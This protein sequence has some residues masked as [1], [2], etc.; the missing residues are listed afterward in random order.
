MQIL[1][2]TNSNFN[3]CVPTTHCPL[4]FFF[5]GDF[6]VADEPTLTRAVSIPAPVYYAHWAAQRG[7]EYIKA[8]I[9]GDSS[10]GSIAS[11]SSSYKVDDFRHAQEVAKRFRGQMY[12]I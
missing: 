1:L 8:K 6:N 2:A 5:H 10:S 7:K 11:G 3:D 9:F 4:C 12:F